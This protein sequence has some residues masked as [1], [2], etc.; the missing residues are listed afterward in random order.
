MYKGS[1]QLKLDKLPKTTIAL[2]IVLTGV[3]IGAL[4]AIFW[5]PYV[6]CKVVRKD[7]T[8]RWFHFFYGPLLWKREAPADADIVAVTGS[9][10]PDYRFY[11]PEEAHPELTNESAPVTAGNPTDGA[12]VS[13]ATTERP[14]SDLGS[15]SKEKTLDQ[16]I[17]SDPRPHTSNLAA[18]EKDEHKIHGNW[19]TPANLYI[20]FRYKIWQV[21]T[22]GSSVDIHALQ[23]SGDKRLQEMH[24]RAEAYPNETEHL[25][26]FL[27]GEFRTCRA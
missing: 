21:I 2:A 13:S 8:I 22:H 3:V 6:Y 4:A 23:G 18:V 10:V 25:F 24:A 14:L 19:W 12:G 5:L 17:E 11:R 9:H 1:P 20:I 7:Y 27:Q 15:D 16:D 26:S